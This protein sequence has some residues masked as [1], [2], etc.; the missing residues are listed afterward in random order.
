MVY[1]ST[2]YSLFA[3]DDMSI[4]IREATMDD[5]EAIS[6]VLREVDSMHWDA[7]PEIFR[8]CDEPLRSREYISGLI[9]AENALLLLAEDSSRIVGAV[10]AVLRDAPDF[11]LY[12]PRRYAIIDCLAVTE[13]YRRQGLGGML[14]ESAHSWAREN[15]ATQCELC[16]W[17]F[18]Q[19]AIDFY[20]ELGYG[21]INRRMWRPI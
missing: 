13:E 18:N 6:R 14:M 7:M 17:E 8:E 3:G 19:N 16:V 5:Y 10:S 4:S 15:G 12:A 1:R 11:Q 20:E 21:T 2:V 9:T